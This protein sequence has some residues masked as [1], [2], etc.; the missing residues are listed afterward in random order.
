MGLTPTQCGLLQLLA[1]G[2]FHSGTALG[3]AL[4]ISRTAI[5]KALDGIAALGVQVERAPRL[6]YRV[7]G[8]IDLHDG[9]R[10]RAAL[11]PP[12]R[13]LLAELQVLT[14]TESTNEIAK[15]FAPPPG[16]G[17]CCLAEH[18][19]G[20][21]GRLGR[22]WVSPFARN[23]YCSLAWEFDGGIA[24]L[25]GLSLAVGVAV[26]RALVALG[27]RNV[28]MK[29]PNDLLRDGRKLGGILVEVTGDP[30]G[31]CRTVIGIGINV[32]MPAVAS[33]AID[34]PWSDLADFRIPRD[35][36]AAAVLTELLPLLHDFPAAGFAAHRAE[37]EASDHYR[38]QPVAISIGSQR[39]EG[40]ARGVN[41]RG[42]LALECA[43]GWHWFSGGEVSL[44]GMP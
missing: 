24:A 44:R 29:W 31:R 36:L 34:Q 39:H 22:T 37:W 20:G 27:A 32:A 18:Q 19:T 4:G 8:G 12:V 28:G 42:A 43:D 9:E 10:I 35:T 11:A 7:A 5:W 6:G 14:V 40:I 1:D 17:A 30:E 26:R 2:A 41:D 16:Q 13:A 38:D 21:R 25:E 3:A 15:R 33:A 23:L